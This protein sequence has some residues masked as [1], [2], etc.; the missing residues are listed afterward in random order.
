MI[1][2]VVL[3]LIALIVLNRVIE[4]SWIYP[5]TLFCGIWAIAL[6]SFTFVADTF[7]P[8][9]DESLTVYM[10]GAIG[11]SVGGYFANMIR[12][13]H[14][15]GLLHQSR[16]TP[17]YIERILDVTLTVQIL[18]VPF[19][20][21]Y[22]H[23]LASQ[24]SEGT[25]WQ[26]IRRSELDINEWPGGSAGFHLAPALVPF[27]SIL[28]II[29]SFEAESTSR[30][31]RAWAIVALAFAYQVMGATRTTM[32]ML[33][34]G[35][36]VARYLTSP[37]S[38]V[39]RLSICFA[40]FA[41]V[42]LAN[43]LVLGKQGADESASLRQNSTA[44]RQ[45]IATYFVGSMVAFDKEMH[46]ESLSDPTESLKFL[47]RVANRLGANTHEPTRHLDFTD[48]SRA[49]STNTYTLYMPIYAHSGSLGVFSLLCALGAVVTAVYRM[50]RGGS[51]LGI[52]LLHPLIFGLL[53]SV[54]AECFSSELTYQLKMMLV[55]WMIYYL[56]IRRVPSDLSG[57]RSMRSPLQPRP[58]LR[59]V[60][61]HRDFH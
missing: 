54:F 17:V 47:F 21:Q 9:H 32:L 20:L 36:L 52:F 14:A 29:A 12:G 58:G 34:L 50:A 30:K 43:N 39:R 22:M 57:V 5:P 8:V 41:V 60:P 59:S 51:T 4:P 25:F 46:N 11:F 38:P 35:V 40:V 37:Q 56:P 7:D 19:Y 24:S 3:L 23:W 31:F 53:M 6:L 16:T 13:R 18:F 48:I 42:V 33:L 44:L 45:G 55:V 26:N 28:A 15:R 27:F 2:L 10:T 49:A 61:L 1:W